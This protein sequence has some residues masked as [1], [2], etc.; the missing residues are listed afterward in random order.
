M[1]DEVD[2]AAEMTELHN[3]IRIQAARDAAQR[4]ELPP[5]GCC[6]NCDRPFSD[7]EKEL[8]LL[9]C[10]GGECREDHEKRMRLTGGPR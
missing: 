7:E 1:A 10:P 3:N 5:K 9:Y 4:R 8:G 2:D 6:Y